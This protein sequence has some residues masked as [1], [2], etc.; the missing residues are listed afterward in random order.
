MQV[1]QRIVLSTLRF[2]NAQLLVGGRRM[3]QNAK[4][5]AN[6]R[7]FALENAKANYSTRK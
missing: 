3:V 5:R 4:V 6:E 2:G 1:E 7:M